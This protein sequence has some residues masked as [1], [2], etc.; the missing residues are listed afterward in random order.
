MPRTSAVAVA[1]VMQSGTTRRA[2][3][4]RSGAA[5]EEKAMH[6]VRGTLVLA[7]ALILA[8]S[9]GACSSSNDNNCGTNPTGPG[10]SPPPTTAPA[11]SRSV[12]KTASC[13]DL[14]VNF[15]CFFEPFTTSQKGDLDVTVDWTYPEDRI[16][17][18]V[19]GGN[20][21]LD[22]INGGQCNYIVSSPA[23]TTPKPRV[24]MVKAVAAGS[25][26]L[27][28]G[29]RGPQLESVSI[30]IGLTTPGTALSSQGV[31]RPEAVQPYKTAVA[32]R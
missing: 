2:R 17:V 3:T 30:Q 23:A 4:V 12:I 14:G 20:C 21:T 28:V 1:L 29:N 18:M 13:T 22:Q 9:F 27:Y 6:A 16:Q 25:Y 19:S 31:G 32:A 5:E 7:T 26:T 8:V 10:C 24:L 11:Q 15:L